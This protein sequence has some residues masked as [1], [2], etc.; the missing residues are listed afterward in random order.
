MHSIILFTLFKE[1]LLKCGKLKVSIS[2]RHFYK[3]SQN[4]TMNSVSQMII[5]LCGFTTG[6]KKEGLCSNRKKVMIF[7]ALTSPSFNGNF[8]N[9]FCYHNWGK[10]DG[11][12]C[13]NIY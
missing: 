2:A 10:G 5:L 9:I 11:E 13:F 8:R 6:P 4:T 7:N 12:Q 3:H 1:L